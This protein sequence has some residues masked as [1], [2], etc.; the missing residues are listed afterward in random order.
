MTQPHPLTLSG[1]LVP[2]KPN[3]PAPPTQSGTHVPKKPVKRPRP[4]HSLSGTLVPKKPNNPAPPTHSIWYP[5]AQET[6]QMTQPHPLNLVSLYP[7]KPQGSSPPTPVQTGISTHHRKF[8][9]FPNTII[10]G[11]PLDPHPFFF[12]GGGVG[13]GMY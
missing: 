13:G 6:S 8:S 9:F 3:D 4:T 1:T 7:K 2:K 5:C 11:P 10:G 12:W